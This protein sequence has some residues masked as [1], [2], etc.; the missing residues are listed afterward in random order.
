MIVLYTGACNIAEIVL[1]TGAGNIAD[2]NVGG[3]IE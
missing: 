1:Y 2:D 3:A